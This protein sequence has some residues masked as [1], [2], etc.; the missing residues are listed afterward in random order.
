MFFRKKEGITIKEFEEIVSKLK[1]AEMISSAS[2]RSIDNNFT[3]W[4]RKEIYFKNSA[5]YFTDDLKKII[6]K[7]G[8]I[9]INKN[10]IFL[11]ESVPK[12]YWYANCYYGY[13]D[14][15]FF[16][17]ETKTDNSFVIKVLEEKSCKGK[18]VWDFCHSNS[19]Y[20]LGNSVKDIIEYWYNY[21]EEHSYWANRSKYIKTEYVEKMMPNSN[22]SAEYSM[23]KEDE[24]KM[25]KWRKEHLDKFH[26]GKIESQGV[27]P[28]DNFTV[29]YCITGLGTYCICKCSRCYDKYLEAKQ[30]GSSQKELTKLYDEAVYTV[31]EIM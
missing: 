24:K 19:I 20:D 23:S 3:G 8:E 21:L 15:N 7:N 27:T 17:L 5:K 28:V 13:C 18:K 22:Y 14:G 6:T 1:E 10:N 11:I 25:N 9:E 4:N 16:K 12:F 26:N 29:E 2:V 31:K 30:K